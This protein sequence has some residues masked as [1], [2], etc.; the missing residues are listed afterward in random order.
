MAADSDGISALVGRCVGIADAPWAVRRAAADAVAVHNGVTIDAIWRAG[1]T[2]RFPPTIE[3]V[4][5]YTAQ[6]GDGLIAIAK[7][8]G[9]G[10][11]AAAQRV[12]SINAW[13][14][15]TPHAGDTWYGGA[16]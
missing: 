8:L 9:L 12:A 10:G 3:G 2:I 6:A 13:Q 16:A 4:R 14:G 5:S 7:G 11:S 15:P 1:D